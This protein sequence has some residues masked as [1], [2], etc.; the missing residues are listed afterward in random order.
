M[1]PDRRVPRVDV[2]NTPNSSSTNKVKTMEMAIEPRQPSLLEKKTNIVAFI[3]S[4]LSAGFAD[5]VKV[6]LVCF[7]AA[8][9]GRPAHSLSLN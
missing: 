5:R 2:Q 3:P 9:P 7:S 8:S 6:V 4:A 1:W